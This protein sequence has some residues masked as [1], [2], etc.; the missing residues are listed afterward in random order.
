MIEFRCGFAVHSMRIYTIVM[1]I[2][3]KMT[4]WR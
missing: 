4:V 1:V 2:L 3:L